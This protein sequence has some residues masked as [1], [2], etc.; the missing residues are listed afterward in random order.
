MKSILAL[1]QNKK[2]EPPRPKIKSWVNPNKT[3]AIKKYFEREGSFEEKFKTP[4]S[5]QI[6]FLKRPNKILGVT[7]PT[8]LGKISSSRF[9]L[10]LE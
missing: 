3:L 5:S 2:Q 8:P 4:P 10:I 1:V 7:T 6:I 9:Q